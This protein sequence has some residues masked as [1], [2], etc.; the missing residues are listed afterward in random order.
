MSYRGV[1]R[2]IETAPFNYETDNYT[3]GFHREP[4]AD[5]FNKFANDII[6]RRSYNTSFCGFNINRKV[7]LEET[8]KNLPDFKLAITLSTQDIS[9]IDS[10]VT[11]AKIAPELPYFLNNARIEEVNGN[12]LH[13]MRISNKIILSELDNQIETFRDVDFNHKKVFEE[14]Y[15]NGKPT[16]DIVHGSRSSCIRLNDAAMQVLS[17]RINSGDLPSGWVR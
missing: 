12:S 1:L 9:N 8:G 5:L 11:T 3:V 4:D 13:I 10:Y 6:T 17:E 2:L 7:N 14:N 15:F 16:A